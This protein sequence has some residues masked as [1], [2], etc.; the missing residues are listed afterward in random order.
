MV[1]GAFVAG[2]LLAETEY[3]KGIEAIVEPF[4]GLL[5][6]VFFFTIGM[7]IDIKAIL[8]APGIMAAAVGG[9]L[10]IKA[11]IL[12][13][14]M[15][16]NRVPRMAGIETSLLLSPG[17]ELAFVGISTATLAGVLEKPTADFTIVVIALSMSLIPLLAKCANWLRKRNQ[18]QVVDPDLLAIPPQET[19]HA[20]VVGYGRVGQVICAMLDRHKVPYIASDTDARS[21]S[22]SR[23][24]GQRVFYGNATDPQFLK[25]CNIAEAR[26]VIVTIHTPSMIERVVTT[27]RGLRADIPIIARARDAT[28]ASKLYQLGVNDAV[29]ETIEASLQLSE[30]ALVGLGVPMGHVI[31]SIHEKRDEFRNMLQLAASK[32]GQDQS[33]AIRSKTETP[34]V[35]HGQTKVQSDIAAR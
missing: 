10:A 9:L 31:A 23:K 18:S 14:V 19:G 12:F 4:K 22:S 17:G 2:L 13:L 16:V 28:H 33:R 26:A 7:L 15:R 20:I 34:P 29:P 27:V 11:S 30:A 6:G 24:S 25:S 35:Q 5:L 3:R 1:L 21:V 32:A 8:Q